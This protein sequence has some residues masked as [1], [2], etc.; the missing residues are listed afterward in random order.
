MPKIWVGRTTL[1]GG[2][3][4]DG[5][6]SGSCFELMLSM[7]EHTTTDREIISRKIFIWKPKYWSLKAIRVTQTWLVDP[8]NEQVK[9]AEH[10]AKII[11]HKSQIRAL[12]P[13]SKCIKRLRWNICK[14]IN[15]QFENVILLT[16]GYKMYPKI[17]QKLRCLGAF[18][19]RPSVPIGRDENFVNFEFLERR[20]CKEKPSF[21]R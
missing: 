3:K 18:Q 11:Q 13:I 4:E 16:I 6:V 2:K 15:F 1:D 12:T 5:L 14:Y 20:F 19:N 9:S 17:L 21:F 7:K 8:F 10:M